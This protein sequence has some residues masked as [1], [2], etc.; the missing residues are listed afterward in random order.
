MRPFCRELRNTAAAPTLA[1]PNHLG[2]QVSLKRYRGK[3]G[4]VT[5]L[6][7]H[8]VEVCPLIVASLKVVLERLG[9]QAH[10]VQVIA[11]TVDP[12][13][14]TRTTVAAFLK[15]HHMTGRM[16]Y[17]IGSAGL[18][19]W[20]VPAVRDPASRKLVTHSAVT[21][22][23]ATGKLWRGASLPPAGTGS[24]RGTTWRYS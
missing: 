9:P 8:C 17:L 15:L 20:H 19:V 18:L 24:P 4:L 6:Y 5:F 3:A 21:G 22:V 14:D 23:S 1:L 13:G 10:K 11:V 16:K 2:D 7:T 12:R